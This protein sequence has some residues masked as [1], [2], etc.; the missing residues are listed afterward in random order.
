MLFGFLL[1]L[2]NKGTN[3]QKDTTKYKQKI[4]KNQQQYDKNSK[5]NKKIKKYKKIKDIILAIKK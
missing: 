3:I 5:T 2:K 1:L 4:T